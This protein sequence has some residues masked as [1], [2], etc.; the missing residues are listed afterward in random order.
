MGPLQRAEEEARRARHAK[1]LRHASC[2]RQ[3]ESDGYESMSPPV[4]T[5]SSH[6]SRDHQPVPTR[7]HEDDENLPASPTSSGPMA[8]NGV[9]S[10]SLP[11]ASISGALAMETPG[12]DRPI[13]PLTKDPLKLWEELGYEALGEDFSKSE[14]RRNAPVR[15]SLRKSRSTEASKLEAARRTESLERKRRAP[16]ANGT[17]TH[18]K[19]K[20]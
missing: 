17:A 12:D 2:G 8:V 11:P 7:N 4:A 20:I 9:R 13:R 10:Q 19:Q 14:P 16:Q 6:S 18:G 1:L 15:Q 5:Q 3:S